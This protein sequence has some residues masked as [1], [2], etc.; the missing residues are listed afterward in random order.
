[1]ELDERVDRRARHAEPDAAEAA[2]GQV[3]A[4]QA[5]HRAGHARAPVLHRERAFL[6]YEQI[7]DRDVVAAGAA[8]AADVPGVDDAHQRLR[9]E[10]RDADLLVAVGAQP[11]RVAVEDLARAV[12]QVR[13]H[14]AAG[15][16]PV[17][18]DAIAAGRDDRATA[19]AGRARGDADGLAE[20]QLAAD[21]GRQLGAL[22][23]GVDPHRHAPAG[24]AVGARDLLDHA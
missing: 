15:E 20:E 23:K 6:R 7:L 9:V 24:G 4:V 22:A 2:A 10:E 16:E 3:E 14:A 17:P 5:V 11:R 19:L 18:A 8:Q 13:V 1:R 21:L 12:E